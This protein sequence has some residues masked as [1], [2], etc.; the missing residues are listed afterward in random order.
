MTTTVLEPVAPPGRSPRPV[1]DRTTVWR[2]L[3][4]GALLL[5][6]AAL[7]LWDLGAGGWANQF[8]AAAVQAGSSSWKAMLFGSSDAAGAITVDKTP[9]ALWVMDLSARLFGFN[10]WS[11][12]VPQALEGVATVAVLYAAV[13]RVGGHG[14]GLL[15]GAVLA[16]TPVAALMFRYDNPDSL[17]VLMLTVAAY[18][19]LR[20][21][22]KDAAAWWLPLAGVAIGFGFLAKMMQA[23]L[24]LPAFAVAYLLAAQGGWGKRLWRSA[25]ALLTLVV[26]AGWYLALV[27]LWPASSRPYIGGSQHNS[28]LEL[29][30]GYNG[31]GRITGNETGGLGNTNFDVGW[32]RLF[33]DEMGGD[34]AW[35]IPAALILTVAGL[36]V[37]RRAPRTDPAR[38]ALVLWLG[39]LVVTGAV[40]SYANGILHPYYTV[41]LAPA[42]GGAVGIGASLMW[43]RRNDIRATAVLS[44]TLVVT[45]V[46]ADVLLRRTPQW[47]SWLVPVVT[48]AGVV[49][50]VAV[51]FVGR[52]PRTLATVATLLA[53]AAALAGPAAYS[54]ATAATTHGG[55]IPSAGPGG[56]GFGGR[57]GPPDGGNRDGNSGKAFGGSRNSGGAP[58]QPGTAGPGAA[59]AGTGPGGTGPGTGPGGTGSGTGSGGTGSGTGSGGTGSGTGSGAAS[60]GAG[61]G[62]PRFGAAAGGA[63]GGPNTAAGPGIPGSGATANGGT[64]GAAGTGGTAGAAGNG[65]TTGAAGNGG[66][67][68][69]GGGPMGGMF[70][71]DKASAQVVAAL[72]ANAGDY[73][74]VAAAVGSNNA[75]T[76]QLATRDPVMAIG[77]YNATDPAPT[78]D[79]FREYVAQHK[80][81]YYIDGSTMGG[82]RGANSGGSTASTE[83]AAWVKANFTAQTIDG[84]TVYDLTPGS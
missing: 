72:T 81:H 71:S 42:V 21:I 55:P 73:T 14:A 13:R 33:G 66:G 16:V 48:V 83:I 15:A 3:S 12:L 25:T 68:G 43:Q 17:L 28:V 23:F 65:G 54:I 70:G 75:A 6:T 34:I 31:V 56:S 51:L 37:L 47:N 2:R 82:M 41:A 77:G 79:R 59:G 78:L 52:L 1:R 63:P 30:L 5:A 19:V 39:W 74:W 32:D 67:G 50:A 40:F 80:I 10:A 46:L 9:G 84:V 38:A 45:V 24:V 11:L 20:A 44:G 57:H 60:S 64:T 61:Q 4:L 58:G 62:D 18:C 7:Y 8:Y 22:E 27:A 26:S 29:A 49:A 69:F 76:Y 36:W 53:V 35:L